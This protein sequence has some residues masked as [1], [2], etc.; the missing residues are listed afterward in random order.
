MGVQTRAR[1]PT[2]FLSCL[3]GIYGFRHRKPLLSTYNSMKPSVIFVQEK[4]SKQP[5]RKK[6]G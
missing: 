4:H 3:G 2:M 5:A 6:K 1:R